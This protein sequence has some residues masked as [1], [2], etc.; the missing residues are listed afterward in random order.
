MTKVLIVKNE[1]KRIYYIKRY[2]SRFIQIEEIIDELQLFYEL[3]NQ[4]YDCIVLPIRGIKSNRIVD[5]TSIS[6]TDNYLRMAKNKTIY[7]GLINKELV[8]KCNENKIR[9][10]TY[11]NEDTAIKN[12]Y[13]TTEGI[14]EA[15]VNN[16][17]KG[18][19]K[20]N[21]LIIGYGKLGSICAK[22][23]KKF[24]SK[25]TIACRHEKD[26]LHAK[27]S[28]FNVVNYTQLISVINNFDFIIN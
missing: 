9:L 5:G 28:D 18:I 11:L 26:S 12:N 20:S 19:Y 25:I 3:Q 22:I 7:T 17:D 27:I 16:S 4:N 8:S 23:L 2:L 10:V 14:V 1:D 24:K 15:I 13:L 6:L 21:I